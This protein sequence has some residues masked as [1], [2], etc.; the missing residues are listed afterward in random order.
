[1]KLN[2]RGWLLLTLI[3][4]VL[5]LLILQGTGAMKFQGFLVKEASAIKAASVN[6]LTE[7]KVI[8]RQCSFMKMRGGAHDDVVRFTV[9]GKNVRGDMVTMYVYSGWPFKG[10]TVRTP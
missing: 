4:T 3:G 8:K 1:M 10:A 6:G 2:Y 7:V 9:N 5:L